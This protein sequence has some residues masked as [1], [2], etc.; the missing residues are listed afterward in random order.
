MI[1]LK[2]VNFFKFSNCRMII[3]QTT[4]F[5]NIQYCKIYFYYVVSL[6]KTSYT[7]SASF[8]CKIFPY[9]LSIFFKNVYFSQILELPHNIAQ[10][11]YF[12]NI[13]YC[14]I[15]FHYG[16]S[17][18]KTGYND[19]ASFFWKIF[20]FQISIFFKNIH[21]SQVFKL[22]HIYSP[23]YLFWKHPIL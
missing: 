7:D 18:T 3:A 19:S 21:F 17:L 5:E 4:Y 16:L 8:F 2:D 22:L 9:Q 14:R 11:T 6:A 15:Y 23:N 20:P 13:Q 10:T 1:F 12:E